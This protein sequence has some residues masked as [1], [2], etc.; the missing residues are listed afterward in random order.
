MR[1]HEIAS[2]AA[3]LVNGDRH[4]THG[5]KTANHE[6][7]A[8]LWNG[9]LNAAKRFPQPKLTAHDVANLMECLKIARRLNGAFNPDDYIDAAGYAGVAGEIAAPKPPP[10][11]MQSHPPDRRQESTSLPIHESPLTATEIAEW[12]ARLG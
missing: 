5:D 9:Y 4:T 12:R 1:A 7:I 2:K 8:H 3:E 10:A 11:P 6:A